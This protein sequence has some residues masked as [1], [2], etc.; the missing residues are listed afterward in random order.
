MQ[1]LRLRLK[2]PARE[3]PARNVG[4]AIAVFHRLLQRGLLEGLL[5]DVA[6]YQHVPQGPGVLLIGHDVD[7]GVDET[8][9]SVLRKR[10]QG[11]AAEV[12]TQLRD[13]LRMGL[14]ALEALDRDGALGMA[15]DT[16]HFM[17]SVLDRALTRNDEA[18]AHALEA[19][20]EAVVRELFGAGVR[21]ARENAADP[22]SALALSV[23]T[24]PG[25]AVAALEKLG[26]ARAPGQ[27]P[28]DI[29]VE[30]L[31]RLRDAGEDVLLLDVREANE[32][33]TVNLGGQLAP[34]ATLDEQLGA[35][36]KQGHIIVHCKSGGRGARAVQQLRDAG[37]ENA[38]NL[39]GGILAWIERVDPS[40]PR[41]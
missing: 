33:E 22:R 2:F 35:L 31:K 8:G 10:Q 16:E 40:L 26:G 7:Y 12:A 15:F 4:V 19:E 25:S 34:L 39:N 27:S 17:V 14:G 3:A 36:P 11:D 6:D 20:L 5:L 28:W 1:P 41:Y 29:P 38:W 21:F 32:F 9:F 13:A 23:Q 37:F 24:K 30:E 18:A